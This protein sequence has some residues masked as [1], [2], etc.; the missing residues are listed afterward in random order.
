M[1]SALPSLLPFV[2]VIK[3]GGQE[4]IVRQ[5]VQL[6]C[7]DEQLSQL[8]PLL[9][10][11][12]SFVLSTRL[13]QQIMRRDMAVYN[14]RPRKRLNKLKVIRIYPSRRGIMRSR[15]LP[16]WLHF[17]FSA[18]LGAALTTAGSHLFNGSRISSNNYLAQGLDL[19]KQGKVSEAI[20]IYQKALE[21]YPN[22]ALAYVN[23]GNALSEQGKLDE[24]IAAYNKALNINPKSA[25]A[26]WGLGNALSKQEKLDEAIA[27]YRKVIN[28]DPKDATAYK[29]LGMALSKQGKIDEGLAAYRKALTI[30]PN[31]ATSYASLAVELSNQEKIDEA[32]AAYRKALTIDPNNALAYYG[33]GLALS[34]QGKIDEAIT[35]YRKAIE[36]EPDK[37]H[38][39]DVYLKLGAALSKQNKLEEALTAYRKAIELKP[40]K[41][42]FNPYLSLGN[43]LFDQGKL[44]EAIALFQKAIQLD[45]ENTYAY[46]YLGMALSEQGK[47]KEGIAAY[48]R[49]IQLDP[50]SEYAYDSLCYALQQQGKFSEAIEQCKRANRLSQDRWLRSCRVEN[51][52][53]GMEHGAGEK[54][55]ENSLF[56]MLYDPC[57]RMLMPPNMIV[58]NLKEAERL[59][60]FQQNPQLSV[61][62]E[63]LPSP[64]DEPLV[65][66][67]RSVVRVIAKSPATWGIGTGWLVKREGNKAWIVT[68]RHVVT[69]KDEQQLDEQIEV[70]F[71]STPPPGQFRKRRPARIA[72]ITAANDPLDLAVLE[73]TGIP[74][75]IQS[76][77]ISSK[78]VALK[79]PIRVIGHPNTGTDW[80]VAKGEVSNETDQQLQLSAIV[81]PGISGGPVLDQQNFVV[82][83]AFQT[84]PFC[85]QN[86]EVE[87]RAGCGIALPMKPVREQLHSWG[88]R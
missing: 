28:I 19:R 9:A 23:L 21:I 65:A 69:K 61:M 31:D 79:T 43:A 30:D 71:Y 83:V 46:N 75:N 50:N 82:G 32:I 12:A 7:A 59:L 20:A 68:N 81:A 49:V 14:S 84:N 85:N 6:L 88:I 22:N 37:T 72:K 40:D 41:N 10:F 15:R 17:A 60:A 56:P 67:K 44:D 45:P 8:E 70:E 36:L 53:E 35:A 33:M 47:L 76:L 16:T 62:P 48:R 29:Y 66:L 27:A 1:L 18:L 63:H 3:G 2:P 38:N 74:E 58:E 73:V 39:A 24:A 13:V 86:S 26:Y 4:A 55:P 78:A 80:T 34:K 64:K 5:A 87:G 42:N 52:A 51:G 77:P 54:N 57:L 11:F 25:I